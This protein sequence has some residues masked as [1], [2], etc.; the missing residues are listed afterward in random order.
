MAD[1][2]EG[3][4]EYDARA[5]RA[6]AVDGVGLRARPLSACDKTWMPTLRNDAAALFRTR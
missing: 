6:F 5:A 2:F 4:G 1:P 3:F